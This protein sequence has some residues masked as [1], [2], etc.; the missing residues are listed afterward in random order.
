M[1]RAVLLLAF[2]LL[3]GGCAR[4]DGRAGPYLGGSLGASAR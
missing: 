1:T 3:A 4:E 2:L